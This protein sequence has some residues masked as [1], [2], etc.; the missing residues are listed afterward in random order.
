[1]GT[2]LTGAVPIFLVSLV[3]GYATHRSH[4]IVGGIIATSSTTC[5]ST[6]RLALVRKGEVLAVRS[7]SPKSHSRGLPQLPSYAQR[8]ACLPNA[9][10]PLCLVLF[11][12]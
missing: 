3:F 5:S 4:S 6:H 1:M 2:P 9:A 12:C 11:W 10:E 8:L 7:T